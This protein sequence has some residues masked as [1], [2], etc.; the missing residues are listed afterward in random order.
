MD[1]TITSSDV[2]LAP[3]HLNYT[4]LLESLG[5]YLQVILVCN[6]VILNPEYNLGCVIFYCF[7]LFF[8]VSV[9]CFR[10][11]LFVTTCSI[12]PCRKHHTTRHRIAPS[13][14]S[15]ILFVLLDKIAVFGAW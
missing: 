7:L 6:I 9:S 13:G 1:N 3:T 11:F 5:D 15:S 12:L 2:L 14:A 8:I 4:A 10:L